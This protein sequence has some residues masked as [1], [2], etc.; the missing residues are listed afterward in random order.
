MAKRAVCMTLDAEIVEETKRQCAQ[1]GMTVSGV[2]NDLLRGFCLM[3]KGVIGETLRQCREY[4]LDLA[5]VVQQLL[6]RFCEVG[7]D[8]KDL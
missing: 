6:R 8:E 1:Y 7:N 5:H 2:V 4:E 3:D